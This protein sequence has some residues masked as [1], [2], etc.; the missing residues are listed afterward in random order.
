MRFCLQQPKVHV[1]VIGRDFI[2]EILT[3]YTLHCSCSLI[4][5]IPCKY[6]EGG[7]IENPH[8]IHLSKIGYRHEHTVYTHQ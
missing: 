4:Y 8:F 3:Q 1:Y 6:A 5:F 2:R 7:H